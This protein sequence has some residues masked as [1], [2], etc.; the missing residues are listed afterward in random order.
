MDFFKALPLLPKVHGKIF[1]EAV[2]C[3]IDFDIEA[4]RAF[5]QINKNRLPGPVLPVIVPTLEHE[6]PPGNIKQLPNEL[7]G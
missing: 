3:K 1:P 5:L 4:L 7:G 2:R 6:K